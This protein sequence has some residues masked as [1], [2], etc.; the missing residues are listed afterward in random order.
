[1]LCS[2]ALVLQNSTDSPT[3]TLSMQSGVDNA[4]Q[5]KGHFIKTKKKKKSVN[6]LFARLR[7]SS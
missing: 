5:S 4:A 1:M 2:S 3:A 6:F 7:R